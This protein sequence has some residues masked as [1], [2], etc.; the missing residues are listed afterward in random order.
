M[1]NI[2]LALAVV[3]S[4]GVGSLSSSSADASSW[5]KGVPKEIRGNFGT[6]EYGA[7]L[8]MGCTFR[9]KALVFGASGMP[10]Q[11]GYNVH[12]KRLHRHSYLLRYDAYANGLFKGGRKLKMPV[13]RV[14][15][16][17]RVFGY[18]IIFYR[19]SVHAHK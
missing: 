7:S 14:G 3:T 9:A 13:K 15:K 18:K 1:K 10:T 16:N 19:E 5:H 4:I 12:Y 2:L 6:K 17:L 8:T 11:V